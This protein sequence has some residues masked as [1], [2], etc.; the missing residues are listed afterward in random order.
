MLIA[1]LSHAQLIENQ[2][3]VQPI[4]LLDEATSLDPDRRRR[5]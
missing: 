5:C 2:R 3:M 4:L 1:I